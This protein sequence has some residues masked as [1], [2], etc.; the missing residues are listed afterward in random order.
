MELYLYPLV[1]NLAIIYVNSQLVKIRKS[2]SWHYLHLPLLFFVSFNVSTFSLVYNIYSLFWKHNTPI[3]F[4]QSTNLTKSRH[5]A[6]LFDIFLPP[7]QRPPLASLG[8]SSTPLGFFLR[9]L[10]GQYFLS[11]Q[12]SKTFSL[13]LRI[14]TK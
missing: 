4:S 6:G 14:F 2:V 3:P 8:A 13:L 1:F 10:W 9:N 12:K 11:S 5:T 7:S